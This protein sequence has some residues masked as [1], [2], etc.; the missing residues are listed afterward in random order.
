MKNTFKKMAGVTLLEV[1]LVLA[2][3]AMIIVMSVRYY[4]SATS[5][6]QANAV[7]GQVQAIVAAADQ[8]AQATGAYTTANNG[9]ALTTAAIQTLLP[10]AGMM[11]PWGQAITIGGVTSSAF[12]I[13][14]P[15]TPATVCPLVR[16]KVMANN[17]F[18]STP[19]TACSAAGNTTL[20]LTYTANI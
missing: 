2:I 18:T 4:Q 16:S 14:L 12:T 11:T 5:S 13:T 15:T 20:V 3:A 9:G 19:P 17:H 8:L 7:L 10:A 6:Q 1:M